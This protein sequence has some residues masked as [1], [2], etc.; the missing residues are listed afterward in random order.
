MD[1]DK[2]KSFH[3]AAEA[4]S[5][6][7]AAELLNLSQSAVSRQISALEADLGIKLFHRHTRGLLLTEPGRVLFEAAV[8]VS[9]RVTLAEAHLQDLRDEPSGALR[10]TAPT[11]LG[12]IWLAPRLAR[13]TAAFPQIK[14][15]LLLADHELDVANL[16]ADIAIRPWASRQN[17][18]I[19]RKLMEVD[20]HLYGS[21]AY[22]DRKGEPESEAALDA[23]DFVAY[24]PRHLA[25]IPKLN[26][27]LSLGRETS[28][29]LRDPVIE[30]NTIAGMIKA[31]EAGIGLAGLPRYV[32]HEDDK[33][34][35]VLP[36]VVGPPF[37]IYMLYPQ[38]LRGSRR[39]AAFGDFLKAEAKSWRD[40]EG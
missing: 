33:L 40:A 12:A 6:T 37:E 26:W 1:W 20:Q 25:P 27:A 14:L 9:A 31:I 15:H 30:V 4:G 7:G 35:R 24:G 13:F 8:E 32:A 23:H 34:V 3:A 19:Q 11:A 29:D 21:E 39:V 18:L 2:L 16:E 10:V 38:E 22:F 5:L 17:D 28:A 36:D